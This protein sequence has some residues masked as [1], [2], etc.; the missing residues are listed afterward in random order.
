MKNSIQNVKTQF[1]FLAA[2]NNSFLP[3]TAEN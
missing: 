1:V 2:G 3:K